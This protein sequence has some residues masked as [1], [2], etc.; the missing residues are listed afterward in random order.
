MRPDQGWG[1]TYRIPVLLSVVYV[2]VIALVALVPASRRADVTGAESTPLPPERPADCV[3]CGIDQ[4]CD[5]DTGRC[6]FVEATPLPCIE[7][8]RFDESAGFCLPE[9]GAQ[10]TIAPAEPTPRGAREP[11][12]PRLDLPGFG[13]DDD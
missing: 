6:V 13:G 12:Q 4:T 10:P 9:A 2:L 7:G 8:T 3:V 5:P 11:R 1:G